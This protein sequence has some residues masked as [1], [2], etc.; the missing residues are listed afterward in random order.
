[1][2]DKRPIDLPLSTPGEKIAH[3]V[4]IDDLTDGPQGTSQQVTVLDGSVISD[5]TIPVKEGNEFVDSAITESST[6]I[7]ST[8]R[9]VAP[10]ISV[11][12]GTI[13][14]GNQSL[15]SSGENFTFTNTGNSSIF[16]PLWMEQGTNAPFARFINEPRI[17][18]ILEASKADILVNPIWNLD[19]IFDNRI[20]DWT[21]E[22]DTTIGSVIGIV[23]RNGQEFYKVE[24]GLITANQ[25]VT[26]Q[27][28]ASTGNTP[29]DVF[30]GF[31]YELRLLSAEGDVRCKGS[32]SSGIPFSK[33]G[34]K[35]IDDKRVLTESDYEERQIIRSGVFDDFIVTPDVGDTSLTISSVD[36]SGEFRVYFNTETETDSTGV[37]ITV[38]NVSVPVTM[39]TVIRKYFVNV[40][41]T[42]TI[43]TTTTKIP[44]DTLMNVHLYE[45]IAF[46]GIFIA[47]SLVVDPFV[48]WSDRSFQSLL[49]SDGIRVNG[50]VISPV[51]GATLGIESTNHKIVGNALNYLNDKVDLHTKPFSGISPQFWT[52]ALQ[53]NLALPPINSDSL[54]DPTQ[55][56]NAGVLTIIGGGSNTSTVQLVMLTRLNN[57]II[58][59]GQVEIDD[60]D[61][62]VMSMDTLTFI[63]PPALFDAVEVARIALH[64]GATFSS[65]PDKVL[66]K[67]TNSASIVGGGGGGAGGISGPGVAI[68]NEI[69]TYGTADGKSI[70]ANSGVLVLGGTLTASA[71][72]IKVANSTFPA[73]DE[74]T[75]PSADGTAGQVLSTNGVGGLTFNDSV[76]TSVVTPEYDDAR[77]FSE[78]GLATNQGWVFSG[79]NHEITIVTEKVY[80]VSQF[81][82]KSNDNAS[83]RICLVTQPLVFSQ[84]QDIF[85]F[86]ASFA[87]T[88]RLDETDGEGGCFLGLQCDAIDSPDASLDN[89]R[90]GLNVQKSLTSNKLRIKG[91]DGSAIDIDV[92]GTNFSSYNDIE[93]VIPSGFGDGQV[94]VNG[95]LQGVLSFNVHTGGAGTQC[96]WSSGSS[97]AIDRVTYMSTYGV[98]IYGSGTL[99]Q[100]TNSDL[101]TD[102]SK[103]VFPPGL[104]NYTLEVQ[105]NL[106]GAKVGNSFQIVAQNIG[107]SITATNEN[108]GN[109]SALFN[110]LAN[111]N[112]PVTRVTNVVGLNT[113]EGGNI[114]EFSFGDPLLSTS[115]DE[116]SSVIP[117]VTQWYRM[118]STPD[119]GIAFMD[120]KFVFSLF[121]AELDAVMS[122]TIAFS[123]YI[124]YQPPAFNLIAAHSSYIN[125]TIEAV[126][127]VRE[128]ETNEI[129]AH[130]I[131]IQITNTSSIGDMTFKMHDKSDLDNQVAQRL[132]PVDVVPVGGKLLGLWDVKHFN[133]NL[134]GALLIDDKSKVLTGNKGTSIP[135][136]DLDNIP[137]SIIVIQQDNTQISRG[138][139]V[140]DRTVGATIT[141]TE[142][143]NT[144]LIQWRS[145][146]AGDTMTYNTPI[147]GV[148]IF[149]TVQSGENAHTFRIVKEGWYDCTLSGNFES[150][151]S[152]FNYTAHL[153]RLNASGVILE[154][155]GTVEIGDLNRAPFTMLFSGWYE[156][157]NRICLVKT[158]GSGLFESLHCRSPR[159]QAKWIGRVDE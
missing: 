9:I 3:A 43:T 69:A 60:F 21:I 138:D 89:R 42:G 25:E 140:A 1:M 101:L 20:L 23:N 154:N 88:I 70:V 18:V 64:K 158:S 52:Y 79:A 151:S 93:I 91:S 4:N 118:T 155:L 6:E 153:L 12:A 31:T 122:F 105:E 71:G 131:D 26:I 44:V 7:R 87:G 107:G 146:G 24:L 27:L 37:F 48:T 145:V 159:F 13:D 15:K 130:H 125:T 46:S 72:D 127:L 135:V 85:D 126:R 90:Y 114:Y 115:V 5:T 22:V 111:I 41:S 35:R 103:V 49:E 68:V 16:E 150:G 94:Y 147:N 29:G 95:N 14:V 2:A 8:K 53:V 81:V 152:N 113:Q 63:I 83:N 97:S 104:R 143:N 11:D 51:G 77:F 56:D 80:G 133:H 132:Y 156:A 82:H 30:G 98:T 96:V 54:L 121:S 19:S 65:D 102:F 67:M 84:W 10:N 38:S 117:S 99:V 73:G 123:D 55:Y 157:S 129:S 110:G 74:I 28:D 141:N 57:F 112:I 61:S 137:F 32:N 36:P 100:V 119:N 120:A 149:D 76:T 86:G 92:V 66:I 47:G 124:D 17:E 148:T 144:G 109:P 108:L 62:A 136:T 58:L 34:V 50:L 33:I 45:Y 139:N 59:Y 142:L 116:E 40:D 106:T 78:L 134:S 128:H 39:D 75:Y